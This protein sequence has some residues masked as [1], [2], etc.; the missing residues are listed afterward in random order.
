ME[1]TNFSFN[2]T[3]PITKPDLVYIN[4]LAFEK[5]F[6]FADSFVSC[7]HVLE[8]LYT[9]FYHY[10]QDPLEFTIKKYLFSSG[11]IEKNIFQ[12]N[13][14]TT[15]RSYYRETLKF[16]MNIDY[17]SVIGFTAM[18]KALR[19]MMLLIKLSTPTNPPKGN[20]TE[21]FEKAEKKPIV[22]PDPQKLQEAVKEQV[23]IA[24]KDARASGH[25]HL[26]EGG[27]GSDDRTKGQPQDIKLEMTRCVRDYLYDLDPV[28]SNIFGAERPADVPINRQILMDLKVKAW[29]E[30]DVGMET[31]AEKTKKKDNQSQEKRIIDMES[32]EQLSKVNK[33]A[34]VLPN[35]EDKF[36]KNELKVNEKVSPKIKKQI[37][38]VILDDSGSMNSV[39]KQAYV[40]ASILNRLEAVGKN[41]AELIFY[42][43]AVDVYNRKEVKDIKDCQYLYKYISLRRPNAGGT[44]IAN[45][46]QKIVDEIKKQEVEQ[47]YHDPEIL[48]ICDGDDHVNPKD[49]DP[50]E[51]TI[52][53]ILLGTDNNGIEKIVEKTDGFLIKQKFYSR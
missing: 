13:F 50:K 37:L 18:D 17:D 11:Y 20:D 43:Y 53:A 51:V 34:L 38:Y 24:E 52:S 9:L 29:I 28:I 25:E 30:S 21:D 48:L 32:K 19:V 2:L 10:Q 8:D 4:K 49:L 41:E 1:I 44:N 7:P 5:G 40:R 22:V 14:N 27:A 45:C 39:Y 36:I 31:G 12:R 47:G 42:N 23:K 33:T 26:F 3:N 15:E 35:F 16:L 46:L 6:Q